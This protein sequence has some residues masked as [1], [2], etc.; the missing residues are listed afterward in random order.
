MIKFFK[1]RPPRVD[2]DELNRQVE[3]TN[4]FLAEERPHMSAIARYL[5]W[6]GDKNGFGEDFEISVPLGGRS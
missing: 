4:Q 2:L 5:E 1:R 3:E 6:R